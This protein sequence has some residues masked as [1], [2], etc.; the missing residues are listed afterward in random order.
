MIVGPTIITT[1][2]NASG[3]FL[4]SEYF[5]NLKITHLKA[6]VNNSKNCRHEKVLN[7]SEAQDVLSRNAKY[8][9]EDK[10]LIVIIMLFRNNNSNLGLWLFPE[11]AP[12]RCSR[13][14]ILI[15]YLF[16]YYY[17]LQIEFE[18]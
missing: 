16:Y 6:L 11:P 7:A 13:G 12:V 15:N 3:K 4:L 17:N 14:L 10:V 18:K 2:R 8:I 5:S 9:L 1:R